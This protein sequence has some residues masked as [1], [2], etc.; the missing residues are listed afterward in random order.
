MEKSIFNK[1]A[2]GNAYTSATISTA[3]ANTSSVW[4]DTSG[5]ESA[6]ITL[7]VTAYTS[8]TISG[9]SFNG[10]NLASHSDSVAVLDAN[11][12]YS[13][14]T[15]PINA[16]G[17]Y[18][19]GSAAKYRYIQLVVTTSNPTVALTLNATYLLSDSW[20]QPNST[21]STV[22]SLSQINAPSTEGDAKVTTPK[23][24]S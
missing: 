20:S 15:F 19:I 24:S 2:V 7:N 16:A 9:V 3:G 13:P 22:I 23:R 4:I 14:Y 10:S 8:G 6:I 11:T 1:I 18:M 17:V 5:F 21:S 12:L